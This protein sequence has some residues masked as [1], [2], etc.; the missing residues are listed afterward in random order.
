MARRGSLGAGPRGVE[1][2][3]H[4][5]RDGRAVRL[6]D[7][8]A[9]ERQIISQRGNRMSATA[10]PVVAEL[11]HDTKAAAA[12]PG[13]RATMSRT[14]RLLFRAGSTELVLQVG[15]GRRPPYVRLT[16]QVLDEGTP[17]EDVA[18][19]LLGPAASAAGATDDDGEFQ[20]VNLP[21]GWYGLDFHMR[22]RVVSVVPISLDGS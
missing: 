8:V 7:L 19:E 5:L 10:R 3:T 15:P 6:S 16:G 9:I 12:A 22:T 17:I 1:A 18:V 11:V 13:V 2:D 21:M 20:F 14:R 4:H